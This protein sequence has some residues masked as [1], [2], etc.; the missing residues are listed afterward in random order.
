M[1]EAVVPADGAR[2]LETRRAQQPDPF[3][4]R[5]GDRDHDLG[6][7]QAVVP[8]AGVGWVGDVVAVS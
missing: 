7:E 8:D 3:P 2:D 5:P 4:D 6:R 1:V